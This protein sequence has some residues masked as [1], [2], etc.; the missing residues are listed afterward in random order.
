MA[1]KLGTLLPQNWQY[2]PGT[3]LISAA[4]A[5]EEIGYDSVWVF[6]RV[7]YAQD[8]TG[9]HKLTEY[10]DGTW[11]ELYRQVMDPLVALSMA[12]AVTSRVEVGTAIVV[13][14]LH[15]PFRLARSFASIAA[16]SGGR[17]VAG[18]GSGWSVDE[19]SATA[20]RP[21]AE[22]GAA[23]DEFLDVAA[24]MWAPDPVSFKNERYTVYP[25]EVGPKPAEQIPV[26]LG[27][28]SRRARSRVARRASGWMPS[29]LPPADVTSKYR[30]LLKMADEYG[31]DPGELSCRS[32]VGLSPFGEVPAAGRAPYTGSVD[33][34]LDDLAELAAGGVDEV[35]LTLPF[36][37]NGINE[38]NDLAA[39]FHAKFRL[40]GI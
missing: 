24:A 13:P 29:L 9:I 20:P 33:Q 35:I 30:E 28:P 26:F 12:A 34:V 36:I 1:L 3:D 32:L 38:L 4:K 40:A 5:A 2:V 17:V 25:A 22:R 37:A 31:R 6:E 8:Q 18:L 15:M 19:F 27:G 10:G 23:L 39:E 21:I 7:L 16:S 11:P 14:P